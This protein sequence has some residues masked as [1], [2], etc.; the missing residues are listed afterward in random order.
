M[1]KTAVNKALEEMPKDFQIKEFLMAHRKE[2]EGMLDTEYNE[3]E[4]KELFVADGIRKTV[5][6]LRDLGHSDEEMLDAIIKQYDLKQE[7]AKKYL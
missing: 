2:V 4:V 1:V 3:A 5:A 6:I 7:E